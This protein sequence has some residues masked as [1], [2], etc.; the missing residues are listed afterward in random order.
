MR[1]EP[2]PIQSYPSVMWALR[3]VTNTSHVWVHT[4]TDTHTHTHPNP[5]A[6]GHHRGSDLFTCFAL[7]FKQALTALQNHLETCCCCLSPTSKKSTLVPEVVSGCSQPPVL[8]DSRV[9]LTS[10][11]KRWNRSLYQTCVLFYCLSFK[12]VPSQ[13]KSL[14][15]FSTHITRDLSIL[16]VGLEE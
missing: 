5:A 6:A 13:G 12:A 9:M 4:Y 1:A 11:E 16:T 8:Q 2:H 3:H 15:L 14:G 7:I 10:Q